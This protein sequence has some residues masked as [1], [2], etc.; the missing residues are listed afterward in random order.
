MCLMKAVLRDGKELRRERAGRTIHRRLRRECPA[1][2]Q[3][4]T[5]GVVQPCC[6]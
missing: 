4:Q 6:D 1:I 5:L 2:V 3:F